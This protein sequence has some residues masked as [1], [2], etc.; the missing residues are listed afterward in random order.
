VLLCPTQVAE[1]V[2][3]LGRFEFEGGKEGGAMRSVEWAV[4]EDVLALVP[5]TE[6]RHR[7]TS[8][9]QVWIVPCTCQ[10]CRHQCI[11]GREGWIGGVRETSGSKQRDDCKE[12]W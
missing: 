10:V 4:I 8:V 9:A 5:A 11:V 6:C 2:S 3:K 7:R 12:K 1:E